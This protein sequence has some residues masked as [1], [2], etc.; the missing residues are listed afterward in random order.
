M[1]L[2]LVKTSIMKK[3]KITIVHQLEKTKHH[4]LVFNPDKLT[5]LEIERIKKVMMVE[6]VFVN[7][8][9]YK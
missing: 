1:I 3:T 7:G 2:N 9:L 5:C 4:F 6:M 8:R